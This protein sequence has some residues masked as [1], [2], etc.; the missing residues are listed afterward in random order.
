MCCRDT[1]QFK[2]HVT[3]Q[4]HIGT[5]N[6][7]IFKCQKETCGR[8]ITVKGKKTQLLGK[9]AYLEKIIKYKQEP[10]KKIHF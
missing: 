6:F 4:A 7:K 9:E 5:K 2:N 3:K 8:T 10:Y 1:M